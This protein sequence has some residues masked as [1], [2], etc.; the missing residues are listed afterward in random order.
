[1]RIGRTALL[2][3]T[4]AVTG[5]TMAVAAPQEASPTPPTPAV[6]PASAP[7]AVPVTDLGDMWHRLRNKPAGDPADPAA[8]PTAQSAQRPFFFVSPSI[9]AKPSTGLAVGIASSVVF[10]AGDPATTHISSGDWSVS[11]S[12][13][14]QA[15]TS[16][17]FRMF[18]PENRWL[19]TGDNRL[20]WSNQT[21]YELGIVHDAT[22]EHLKYNRTRIY[23]TL[24]RRIRPQLLVGFGLSRNNHSDVRPASGSQESFDQSAYVAYSNEHGFPTDE[25]ISGGTSVGV[26]LDTRDNAINAGHGWLASATY[27]TFFEGFLGGTSNWQLLETDARTYKSFD[28]EGRHKIAFWYLGEF[29]TG[30]AAPYFDLPSIADDTYGRSARGYTTGRY[31]GPHLVYGEAEYR[32]TLTRNRLLGA[33]FF[34]NTTAVD[35]GESG[36]SLFAS[37]ATAGGAGMRVLLSKRSHANFCVDYSVGAHGSHGLYLAVR[38]TF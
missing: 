16:V 29:V 18:M 6:A 38:E 28:R 27:R 32:T 36:Q 22:G 37:M 13:K 4:L 15:G 31:R 33:V 7:Q 26:V 5:A 21:T 11:D 30:G 12:V 35:G 20:A 3:I 34:V 17:R 24:Y 19:L 2:G 10:V 8:P 9:S 25:Q 23:D 14:G 1:M